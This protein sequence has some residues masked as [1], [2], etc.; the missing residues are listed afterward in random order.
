MI[1]DKGEIGFFYLSSG[2]T[3]DSNAKSVIRITKEI[4]GKMVGDKGYIG[5]ALTGLLFG[6]GAQ[7]ITAVR[8]NKKKL[9]SNEE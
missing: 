2:N 1:N 7:L 3:S 9:L 8:R 5:K 6:D 4:C